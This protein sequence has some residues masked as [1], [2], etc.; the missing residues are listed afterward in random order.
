MTE[1]NEII[2]DAAA[3][4]LVDEEAQA[5]E[6]DQFAIGARFLN[7]L[8]ASH[9]ALGIFYNFTPVAN[10]ADVI[11]SPASANAG[12]KFALAPRMAPLFGI[13]YV[14]TQEAKDA[15]RSLKAR[16]LRRPSPR[17]P[18]NLPVGAGNDN[19]IYSGGAFFGDS[20]ITGNLSQAG[21]T[22]T[23][24]TV[25][26]PV[27]IAGPWVIEATNGMTGTTGGRLTFD[28]NRRLVQI[29]VNL[30]IAT[31]SNDTFNLYL[32]KNGAQL[33]PGVPVTAN[34]A[35]NVYL[36]RTEPIV[37]GDFIEAYLENT[38]DTTDAVITLATL[39][40]S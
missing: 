26:T 14:P 38:S 40:I 20:L 3:I 13:P 36:D 34:Q 10:P 17:H 27:L 5:L 4:V 12:L 21:Q 29:E 7:D 33:A 31:A 37:T 22:V 30:T 35:R 8:A 25:N 23:I 28:G 32:Y 11:T 1:A 15:I 6:P 24:A 39:R 19:G 2:T 16:F 18:R 9:E